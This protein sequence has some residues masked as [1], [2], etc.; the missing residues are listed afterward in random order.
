VFEPTCLKPNC[1]GP[2][3]ELVNGRPPAH[4]G[5]FLGKFDSELPSYYVQGPAYCAS[6][7]QNYM[8]TI[9]H[10]TLSLSTP[11]AGNRLSQVFRPL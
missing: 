2:V 6:C 8:Y 1:S 9:I 10:G 11:D 7:K 5:P 4:P 3:V